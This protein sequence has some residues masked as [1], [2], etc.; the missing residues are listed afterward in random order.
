MHK[1]VKSMMERF[2]AAGCSTNAVAELLTPFDE[3][4]SFVGL[5]EMAARE[6]RFDS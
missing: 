2:M 5:P 6:R 1:A 3:F 4:N